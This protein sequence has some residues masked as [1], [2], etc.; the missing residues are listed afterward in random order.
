MCTI[1]YEL[2]P[3]PV[4]ASAESDELLSADDAKVEI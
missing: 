2:T 1:S 4:C 3:C